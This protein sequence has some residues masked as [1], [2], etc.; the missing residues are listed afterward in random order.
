[1]GKNRDYYTRYSRPVLKT[2]RWQVLRHVILERDGWACIQCG[3]HRHLEVDHII[4]VRDAPE[5]AFDPN[6]L[7]TL[8]RSCHTRKTRL[9]CGHKEKSPARKAWDKCVADLAAESIEQME[10]E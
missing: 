2:K 10:I 4:P 9:E 8:C 1:M 6:G 7:Q 3:S 5:K